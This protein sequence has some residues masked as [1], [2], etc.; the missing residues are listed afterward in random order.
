M[1]TIQS[2]GSPGTRIEAGDAVLSAAASIDTS[3]I[4]GRIAAFEKIHTSYSAAAAAAQKAAE[5]LRAQQEKVAEA[6]VDQDGSV[7]TLA[8]VLPADGL[9]RANPFKPFGVAAPNKVKELGYAREAKVLLGLEKAI[10]KK[11]AS[12]SQQSLD[13]AK[14]TGNA[15]RKVEAA[16]KP[17]AKLEKARADAMA[18]RDALE[19][20]WETAFASLKRGAKAAED[21]GHRGLYAAL[22]ERAAPAKKKSR[23]KKADDASA[24]AQP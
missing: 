8:S 21:D 14:A 5:A 3:P 18:K 16:I 19:Q 6:D 17:I 13:A 4:A 20:A 7:D 11:K 12:F 2:G 10:L 1:P 15:A 9:P 24:P 23:A 22:F